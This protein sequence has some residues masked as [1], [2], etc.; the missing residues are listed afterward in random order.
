MQSTSRPS[1]VGSFDADADNGGLVEGISAACKSTLDLLAARDEWNARSSGKRTSN[2]KPRKRR[3]AL[4]EFLPADFVQS[5]VGMQALDALAVLGTV[6]LEQLLKNLGCD[7]S[8]L[9]EPFASMEQNF[10]ISEGGGPVP[11]TYSPLSELRQIREH[12]NSRVPVTQ[13]LSTNMTTKPPLPAWRSVSPPH[14]IVGPANVGSSPKAQQ[15]KENADTLHVSPLPPWGSTTGAL[16]GVSRPSNRPMIAGQ[17]LQI[18]SPSSNSPPKQLLHFRSAPVLPGL[19][20]EVLTKVSP[21]SM[22]RLQT[23]KMSTPEFSFSSK[24]SQPSLIHLSALHIEL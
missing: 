4:A 20:R 10:D 7:D 1:S 24:P 6:D 17:H 14:R 23:S 19:K 18:G 11:S 3:H 16:K 9:L 12:R 21:S 2:I 8:M 5:N 22:V 13:A 15:N